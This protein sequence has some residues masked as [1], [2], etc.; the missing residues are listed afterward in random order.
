MWFNASDSHKLMFVVRV[1]PGTWNSWVV[2]AQLPVPL[3]QDTMF[4]W[5]IVSSLEALQGHLTQVATKTAIIAW[6]FFPR[7]D[8]KRLFLAQLEHLWE[9]VALV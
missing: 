2:Q 5:D 4:V 6:F 9:S 8:P 7:K 3:S 1:A